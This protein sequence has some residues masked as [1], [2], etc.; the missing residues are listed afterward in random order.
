MPFGIGGQGLI[1]V[2]QEEAL[3]RLVV[4]LV[5]HKIVYRDAVEHA[6]LAGNFPKTHLGFALQTFF[7]VLEQKVIFAPGIHFGGGK[8]IG[9]PQPDEHGDHAKQAQP[10]RQRH[11]Q[12]RDGHREQGAHDIQAR[13]KSLFGPSKIFRRI[14][15]Y[16]PTPVALGAFADKRSNAPHLTILHLCRTVKGYGAIFTKFSESVR[17]LGD[18]ALAGKPKMRK[19]GCER[20]PKALSQPRAARERI[21]AQNRL[22]RA[23]AVRPRHPRTVWAGSAPR[24][25]TRPRLQ[26]PPA[27]WCLP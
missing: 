13:V 1:R 21:T 26:L 8:I 20:T 3:F 6:R 15:V 12:A 24:Q 7:H 5:H 23:T 10:Q 27:D 22:L 14:H 11:A 16:P 25:C 17:T 2:P 19:R 4:A 18:L 9:D